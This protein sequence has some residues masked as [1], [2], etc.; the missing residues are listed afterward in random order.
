MDGWGR[1][2]G[3]TIDVIGYYQTLEK[4]IG[5]LEDKLC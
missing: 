2:M 5:L 1:D 3:H 4:A